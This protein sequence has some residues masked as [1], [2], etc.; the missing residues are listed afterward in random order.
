MTIFPHQMAA[1]GFEVTTLGFSGMAPTHCAIG[2][3]GNVHV[4]LKCP[5][6]IQ[7]NF[8]YDYWLF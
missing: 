8:L 5:N 6:Q 2:N 7:I 4:E 1:V 3:T